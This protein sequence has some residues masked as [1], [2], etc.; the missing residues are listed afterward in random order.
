MIEYREP[1]AASRHPERSEGSSVAACATRSFA[2]R[3]MTSALSRRKRLC[4]SLPSRRGYA[5][6][7]VVVFVALFGAVLGVAW[8][9]VASALRIERAAE[10]RRQCDRGSVQVLAQAMHVLEKRLRK[11]SAGEVALDV[12]S[13]VD[14][15]DYRTSYTCRSREQYDISDDA[16]SPDLRWYLVTFTRENSQQGDDGW[17]LSVTGSKTIPDVAELMPI[18]PP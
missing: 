18:D 9:R 6:M 12:S 15:S 13:N 17:K 4:T 11:D 8:R 14:G 2:A 3:R 10:V 1:R 16:T 5:L 7:L